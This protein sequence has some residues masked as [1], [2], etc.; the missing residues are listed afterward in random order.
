M[1]VSNNFYFFLKKDGDKEQ[2]I[3]FAC[4]Q[5]ANFSINS[6]VEHEKQNGI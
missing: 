2:G 3:S 5:P 4:V 1:Y 6:L